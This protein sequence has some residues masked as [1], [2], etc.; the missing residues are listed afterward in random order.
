M[1]TAETTYISLETDHLMQHQSRRRLVRITVP[2]AFVAVILS[3]VLLIAYYSYHNNR[4]AT[5]VLSNDLLK[6]LDQRIS[7]E[8]EAYLSPAVHMVELVASFVKRGTFDVHEKSELEH[9]AMEVLHAY[10]QLAMFNIADSHGNFLM[11]KKMPDGSIHTKVIEWH[12]G[13]GHVTWI[14]RDSKGTVERTEKSIDNSY[15]P[16]VRPWYVGAVKNR[17]VFWTE[18]YIFFTDKKP[19]ITAAYPVQGPNGNILGVLGLDFE[20]SHLCGFLKQLQIGR[21]GEALIVSDSGQIVAHP[22]MSLMSKQE[23]GKLRPV[24]IDELGSPALLRAFNH[25]RISGP[26]QRILNV[27]G[28]R[29][30]SLV[31]AL[32]TTIGRKWSVFIVVP[33]EDFVGFVAANNRKT[34]ILSLSIVAISAALAILFALQAIRADRNARM[35]LERKHQLEAQSMA[36]SELTGKAVIFD[37]ES[38]EGLQ[39]LTETMAEVFGVSTAGVWHINSQDETLVCQD[40]YTI[41]NHGHTSGMELKRQ[42]FPKFFG[43]V[44][45]GLTMAVKDLAEDPRTDELRELFLD[46]L[47]VRALL[48]VPVLLE[49]KASGIVSF[50]RTRSG[51]WSAEEVSFAQAIAGIV[52]IRFSASKI[53]KEK[54]SCIDQDYLEEPKSS[55]IDIEEEEAPPEELDQVHGSPDSDFPE[56]GKIV[57][58]GVMLE[59]SGA[60]EKPRASLLK[61]MTILYAELNANTEIAKSGSETESIELFERLTHMIDSLAKSYGISQQKMM[62]DVYICLSDISSKTRNPSEIIADLALAMQRE[63]TRLLDE[64][65]LPVQI[66]FGMSSGKVIRQLDK[67]GRLLNLWGE[68]IAGASIMATYGLPGEIQVTESTYNLLKKGYLFQDRGSFYVEGQGEINTYLLYGKL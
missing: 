67:E 9:L 18:V 43:Q 14:R 11:P 59:R 28:Q 22:D 58:E 21:S 68:A 66:R 6:T 56:E 5:L 60:G 57:T 29:Y 26:G 15:D 7:T 53:Y 2:I 40:V 34:L 17:G 3:A 20:L 46:T 19:G 47:G 51:D 8:V 12:N 13:Q 10:P 55:E 41:E 31:S 38:I 37:P 49:G 27:S 33:E 4:K 48:I 63:C 30:I 24:N 32:S 54:D 23:S 36:F 1:S 25:Y 62:G 61:D 35:V 64:L 39:Q 16:R 42:N 45:S 52:S 50:E 44:L 65:G